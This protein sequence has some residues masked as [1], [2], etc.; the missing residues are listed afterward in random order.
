MKKILTVAILFY[1]LIFLNLDTTYAFRRGKGIFG[2]PDRASVLQ[3]E[4]MVHKNPKVSAYHALNRAQFII[5]TAFGLAKEVKNGSLYVEGAK[6]LFNRAK[7]EYKDGNYK[8]AFNYALAAISLA[9]AVL[10][11]YKADH[12]LDVP[13]PKEIK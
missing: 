4:K 9:K 5:P 13:P 10:L 11:T 2:G 1:M 7:N 6:E 8:R 12:P 3:E